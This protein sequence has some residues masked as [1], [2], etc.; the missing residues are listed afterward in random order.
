MML[1]SILKHCKKFITKNMALKCL[2][3]LRETLRHYFYCICLNKNEENP[4]EDSATGKCSLNELKKSKFL[5]INE[6][7]IST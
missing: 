2:L 4:K 6:F 3:W 1:I 7:P 5:T